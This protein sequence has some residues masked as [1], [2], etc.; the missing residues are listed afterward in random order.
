MKTAQEGPSDVT[1]DARRAPTGFLE[2][3]PAMVFDERVMAMR[4]RAFWKMIAA[5][6]K[7][8]DVPFPEY[9]RRVGLR[10]HKWPRLDLYLEFHGLCYLCGDPVDFDDF[11]I[12]HVVPISRGGADKRENLN[13]A[14]RECNY[15]K[16]TK[17]LSELDW[18]VGAPHAG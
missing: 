8:E 13:I 10:N 1:N 14:H 7:G 9:F 4:D 3:N 16:G 12:E 15:R 18:Y 6:C 2:I 11:H 17:L 5:A